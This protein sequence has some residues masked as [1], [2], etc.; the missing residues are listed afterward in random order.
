[1]TYRA[2]LNGQESVLFHR[3]SFS[4]AVLN[5]FPVPVE[6]ECLSEDKR[7]QGTCMN[8]YECR[9]QRGVSHG[10]CA[11]G[12]G[13]CCICELTICISFIRYIRARVIIEAI[14]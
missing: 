9:I 13:V 11:L 12:F 2:R 6:E 14:S 4:L 8:T 3:D 7:R 5:F 1:M 10:P